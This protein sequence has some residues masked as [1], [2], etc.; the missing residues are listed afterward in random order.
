MAKSSP[1]RFFVFALFDLHFYETLRRYIQ[2]YICICIF[3]I[4]F[5]QQQANTAR[6]V[7][8]AYLCVI[9]VYDAAKIYHS[10]IL[11]LC[12]THMV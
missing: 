4:F 9:I 5:C 8:P 1:L 7:A 11:T 10:A 12:L 6:V 3:L 2:M